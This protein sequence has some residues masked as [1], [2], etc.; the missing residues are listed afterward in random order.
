MFQGL[1]IE[2]SDGAS[3]TRLAQLDDAQLPD[4]DVTIRVAYSTLN[5]KDARAITRGLPVVRKLGANGLI[6]R[7]RRFAGQDREPDFNLVEPGGM[8]RGVMKLCN[9][10]ARF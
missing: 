8:F 5:Y 3:T 1:L 6:F 10:T 2:K 7:A 4:G 9:E